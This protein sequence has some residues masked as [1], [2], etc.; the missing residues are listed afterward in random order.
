MALL[1]NL[2]SKKSARGK[3]APDTDD[4]RPDTSGQAHA[5]VE[6]KVLRLERREL[7]YAVIREAMARVGVLSSTYK[8]KVLSLD[9]RGNEY[10]VMMDLPQD[11]ASH[12]DQLAAIEETVVESAR[13]RH[14]I[15]VVAV[16]W[17]IHDLARSGSAVLRKPRPEAAADL[18][19]SSDDSV[20]LGS[21]P[22]GR[23][24][25]IRPE[26]VRAYKDGQR[27]S[28]VV[29][30]APASVPRGFEPTQPPEPAF[31]ETRIDDR[32]DAQTRMP[33]SRTQ[34]GDLI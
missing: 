31:E 30:P 27:P 2:F 22:P 9:S 6:R 23:F 34:Y 5:S 13:Q 32:D 21:N 18:M 25:P 12:L 26:E 20:P 28:P 11:L 3:Q 33:L 29:S 4:P 8:Y 19:V 17:R 1:D 7:L 14:R 24:D 15:T 16:Y 10:L